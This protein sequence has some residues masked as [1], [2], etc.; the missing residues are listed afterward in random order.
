MLWSLPV[1]SC[2]TLLDS[3]NDCGIVIHTLIRN[4]SVYI[5]IYGSPECS[6][7]LTTRTTATPHHPLPILSHPD[8]SPYVD[9]CL[10]LPE[11][12]PPLHGPPVLHQIQ[13][14]PK[15]VQQPSQPSC[16]SDTPVAV[17]TATTPEGEERDKNAE[18]GIEVDQKGNNEVEQV[19][20]MFLSFSAVVKAILIEVLVPP[21]M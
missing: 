14:S 19:G 11:P 5:Y 13:D 8:K 9:S 12:V 10:P 7:Q 1:S 6:L 2:C 21:I 16:M 18:E 4:T 3:K 15:P 20:L 17:T